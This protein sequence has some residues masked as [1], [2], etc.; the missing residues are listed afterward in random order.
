M[1]TS[2]GTIYIMLFYTYI[3]NVDA[4]IALWRHFVNVVLYYQGVVWW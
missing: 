4:I 3:S 2:E 1:E